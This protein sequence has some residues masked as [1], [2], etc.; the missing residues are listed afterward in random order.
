MSTVMKR[1]SVSRI[2]SSCPEQVRRARVCARF[3]G[4]LVTVAATLA[5]PA[6]AQ[7]WQLTD[8]DDLM[9]RSYYTTGCGPSESLGARGFYHQFRNIG[10][11]E[12]RFS[13]HFDYTDHG[14]PKT[15]QSPVAE[16]L[17]PG[18]STSVGGNGICADVGSV[19]WRV[20]SLPAQD[21]ASV[22]RL[23]SPRTYA[24]MDTTSPGAAVTNL[25]QVSI[26][27]RRSS[28]RSL[29]K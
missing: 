24:R 20:S 11:S 19:E 13:Y 16:V 27:S 9:Y 22:P 29:R 12:I 28:S 5:T 18:E 8:I 4:L 15:D 21:S 10:K 23:V 2:E 26:S 17:R 25:L 1:G 6:F 14:N 7:D 3:I